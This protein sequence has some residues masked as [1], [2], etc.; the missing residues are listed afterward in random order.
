MI[1]YKSSSCTIRVKFYGITN[2]RAPT[3]LSI[4]RLVSCRSHMSDFNQPWMKDK[5]DHL[6]CGQYIFY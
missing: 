2:K 3:P 4:Y 5:E 6:G 1:R